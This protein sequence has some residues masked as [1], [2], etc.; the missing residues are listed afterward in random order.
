VELSGDADA[1][2]APEGHLRSLRLEEHVRVPGQG[3]A[4]VMEARVTMRWTLRGLERVEV[5]KE[6]A[7]LDGLEKRAPGEVVV[8][9]EARRR[10]L[11]SR[12]DGLTREKLI[13]V[14]SHAASGEVPDPLR[15]MWRATGLL[16]LHPEYCKDLEDPFEAAS[17]PGKAL[18]LDLLAS[19]G[20]PQAQETIRELLGSKAMRASPDFPALVQRASLL[21]RPTVE[22]AD[23]VADLYRQARGGAGKDDVRHASA[24]T[25]GALI[26][27]LPKDGDATGVA[28]ELHEELREDLQNA[29]PGEQQYLLRALGNAGRADDVPVVVEA[30]HSKS[31]E[32]RY[33]SALALRHTDTPEAT[34]ALVS[35]LSDRNTAVQSAALV[36]L[37]E[38][39]LPAAQ[40]GSIRAAVADGSV[41]AVNAAQLAGILSQ[42]PD[43]QAAK[44]A[45]EALAAREDVDARLRAQLRLILSGGAG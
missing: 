1:E 15:F 8:S 35:L 7:V 37:A 23:F 45:L 40:L 31:E 36:A 29:E 26:R 44:E 12:A 33:A 21:D 10:V 22:T 25:L 27:T 17:A 5:A 28:D 16:R 30:S 9:A 18:I 2:L 32:V 38:H 6:P 19:T 41:H 34:G 42:A 20:H 39:T 24:M 3:A 14:L 43:R 13:D 11:A 4:P